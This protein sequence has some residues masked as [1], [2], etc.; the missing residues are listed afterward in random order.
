M[1]EISNQNEAKKAVQNK[2]NR[3]TNQKKNNQRKNNQRK[4]NSRGGKQNVNN[5]RSKQ[6]ANNFTYDTTRK[7]ITASE[8]TD[9]VEDLRDTFFGTMV[10]VE[11]AVDVVGDQI[12]ETSGYNEHIGILTGVGYGLSIINDIIP[13]SNFIPTEEVEMILEFVEDSDIS[14]IDD[15]LIFD[16]SF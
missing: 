5:Q 9:I 11:S 4:N 6:P 7:T 16:D 15:G 12:Y 2:P 10:A 1:S 8:L 13:L 14:D 3:K